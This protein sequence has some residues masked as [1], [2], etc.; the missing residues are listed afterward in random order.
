MKRFFKWLALLVI[1]LAAGIVVVL[2]NPHL[3]KG[4]LERFLSD[5]T[6]YSI[7]VDGELEIETGRLI[8]ITAKGQFFQ[9]PYRSYRWQI[10]PRTWVTALE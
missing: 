6:G 4:P 10:I 8:E 7:T 3:L 5:L 2:Y 9:G 1:G